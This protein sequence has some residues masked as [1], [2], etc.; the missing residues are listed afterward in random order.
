[1]KCLKFQTKASFFYFT[2]LQFHD[3]NYKAKHFLGINPNAIS[4]QLLLQIDILGAEAAAAAA[5]KD[6]L[7][8]QSIN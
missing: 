7:P 6:L 5:K 1:M 4:L 8:L 2:L 3:K